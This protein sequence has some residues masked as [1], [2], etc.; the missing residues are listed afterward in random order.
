[1]HSN[2]VSTWIFVTSQN[3]IYFRVPSKDHYFLGE[4]KVTM[5]TNPYELTAV[6]TSS[7]DRPHVNLSHRFLG[8][9]NIRSPEVTNINIRYAFCVME[10]T[11]LSQLL[12]WT[13]RRHWM[14]LYDIQSKHT[15]TQNVGV[16]VFINVHH[17]KSASCLL[18]LSLN[19]T[20]F[21]LLPHYFHLK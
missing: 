15:K 1:M 17:C 4:Q 16:D 3:A 2:L 12:E 11:L 19:L 20:R 8:Y 14:Q 7:Y 6:Q 13:L 18:K 9:R 10:L 5:T 21:A